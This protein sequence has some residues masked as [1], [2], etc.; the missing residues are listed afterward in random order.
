MPVGWQQ[1]AP[2][3]LYVRHEMAG[4]DIASDHT[5]GSREDEAVSRIFQMVGDT[6]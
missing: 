3:F 1:D 2:L 5:G 6:N 4:T